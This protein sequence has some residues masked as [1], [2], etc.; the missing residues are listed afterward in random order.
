VKQERP[1]GQGWFP[2][3]TPI[4]LEVTDALFLRAII[5]GTGGQIV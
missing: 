5:A 3:M 1:H 4:F 2:A